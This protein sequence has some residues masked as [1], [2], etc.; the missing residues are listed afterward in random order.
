MPRKRNSSH[1]APDSSIAS[2][3]LACAVDSVLRCLADVVM[4]F[5]VLQ[6]TPQIVGLIPSIPRHNSTCCQVDKL[7]DLELVRGILVNCSVERST[8]P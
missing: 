3:L 6:A 7:V 8:W 4:S 2:P 5:Q 1:T